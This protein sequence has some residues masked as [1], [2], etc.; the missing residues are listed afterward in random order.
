MLWVRSYEPDDDSPIYRCCY[1]EFPGFPPKLFTYKNI[2]LLFRKLPRFIQQIDYLR[3]AI[4][5]RRKGERKKLYLHTFC[6]ESMKN[7]S[8]KHT[9]DARVAFWLIEHVEWN[10]MGMMMIHC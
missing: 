2:S 9:I 1:F 7:K 6:L 8:E 5:N 4:V 10:G 3:Y